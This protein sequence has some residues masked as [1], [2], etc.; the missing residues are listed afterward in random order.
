MTGL[1]LEYLISNF[2][3]DSQQYAQWSQ[4]SADDLKDALAMA[5]IMT[6]NEFDSLSGQ[7]TA[8]LAWNEAQS[9]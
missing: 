4:L 1:M 5:G 2:L 3:I 8:V 7:L 9:E 6:A